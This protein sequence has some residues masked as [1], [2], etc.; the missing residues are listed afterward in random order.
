[1]NFSE[2]YHSVEAIRAANAHLE[3]ARAERRQR[4]EAEAEAEEDRLARELEDVTHQLWF[5]IRM[6]EQGR[7]NAMQAA[8]FV[9]ESLANGYNVDDARQAIAGL[10]EACAR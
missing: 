10:K 2:R 9:R 3:V 6:A 5:W 7:P 4:M 1:M 8:E